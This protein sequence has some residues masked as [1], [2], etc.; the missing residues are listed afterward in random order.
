MKFPGN[1][2]GKLDEN[3]TDV[4]VD[5]CREDMINQEA[6]STLLDAFSNFGEELNNKNTEL[7]RGLHS[8]LSALLNLA[9][10]GEKFQLIFLEN[11][12]VID[13]CSIVPQ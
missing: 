9:K 3:S 4:V 2:F 13:K 1:F 11:S 7:L 5:E 10:D 8:V 12:R 6:V